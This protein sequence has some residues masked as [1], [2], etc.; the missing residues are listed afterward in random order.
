MRL[1][2]E[3]ALELRQCTHGEETLFTRDGMFL[4]NPHNHTVASDG[5]HTVDEVAGFAE[6]HGVN[7]ALTEHNTPPPTLKG[8]RWAPGLVAGIE[9]FTR[10]SLD[11]VVLGTLA[12]IRLLFNE[13]VRG[14]LQKSNPKFRPTRLSVHELLEA[15]QHHGLWCIHPHYAT[16]EGLSI[17]PAKEQRRVLETARERTFVELNAMMT[18]TANHLALALAHEWELP[19]IA[20]GDTHRDERQHVG[21]FSAVPADAVEGGMPLPDALLGALHRRTDMS[22][23]RLY[24]TSVGE[25]L[26]VGTQVVL[27]NGMRSIML[28]AAKAGGR[29]L[30]LWPAARESA[31][32]KRLPLH[33]S[34]PSS[35]SDPR[36]PR[37]DRRLPAQYSP[38][39][40]AV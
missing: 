20:S 33:P 12:K 22:E 34:C 25:K 35:S 11:L 9:V 4:L 1:G 27:N 8:G 36:V 37:T 28:Y 26:A 18:D 2:S 13:A 39:P 32:P 38:K 16:V 19:L 3:P 7:I 29:M 5:A 14:K 24:H 10:E 40:P 21:T 23:D 30:G 6:R 31:I 15:V 17:L